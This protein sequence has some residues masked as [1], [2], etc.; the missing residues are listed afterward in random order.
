MIPRL[1]VIHG[2]SGAPV[3][4][5]NIPTTSEP[6]KIFDPSRKKFET[7]FDLTLELIS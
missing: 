6:N 2:N 7:I 4:G 5:M 3:F 1:N